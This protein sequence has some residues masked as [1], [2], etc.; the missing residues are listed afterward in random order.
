MTAPSL[1]ILRRH[2]GKQKRTDVADGT[3]AGVLD[4]GAP[5]KGVTWVVHRVFIRGAAGMTVRL[6]VGSDPGDPTNADA[7]DEV[8]SVITTVGAPVAANS[9]DEIYVD[10]QEPIW[11]LI[12]GAGA[13]AALSGQ[14]RYRILQEEFY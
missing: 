2:Y 7:Q 14:I 5:P 6:F 8:D 12:T 9:G 10:E 3:G 11:A 4:F 1:G 13:A